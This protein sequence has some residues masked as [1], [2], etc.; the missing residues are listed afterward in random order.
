MKM[1][2]I[3]VISNRIE[4]LKDLKERSEKCEMPDWIAAAEYE[5]AIGELKRLL[6]WLRNGGAD[7][8]R[9]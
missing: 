7:Y 2:I 4:Y 5:Y 3:E 1:K 6:V 9:D 8:D